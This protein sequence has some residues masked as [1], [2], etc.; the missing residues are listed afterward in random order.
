MRRTRKVRINVEGVHPFVKAMMYGFATKY[1]EYDEEIPDKPINPKE[2]VG[3]N[4]N[5]LRIPK[6]RKS[7]F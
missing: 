3:F 5:G 2:R 6:K 4:T 7:P 1:I